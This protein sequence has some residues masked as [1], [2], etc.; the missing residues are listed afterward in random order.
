MTA[1][2][3]DLFV[4]GAGSGGVRAARAAAKYG[5]RTAIAEEYRVGG[6]CVIRGCVPKKLLV[7]A[8]RFAEDFEDAIGFG[9]T[10]EG[11]TFSWPTLIANKNIEVER[12]SKAYVRNV[13]AAGGEVIRQ[14]AELVDRS[15]IRL[16]D[17]SKITAKTI[18]IATGARPFV[19]SALKGMEH[20]ITS[21]EAFELEQLPRRIVIVGGG[22]IAVEFAGIFAGLGCE[23]ILL[24]R[25]EQILRGFDDDIRS[26][27]AAEMAKKGVEIRLRSE[28]AAVERSGDGVRLTLTDGARFGANTV[29]YATGRTPNT[30]GIGLAEAGV[31]LTPQ[32][33]VKV[34][35]YSQSTMPGIY[36]VG[37]VTNRINLTP[38]AVR[39]GQAFA[40]TVFGGRPTAVD[41]T[42]VPSAVFSQPEIGTVGLTER[43]AREKHRSVDIY[44]QSF[45][46]MKHT[47]SGRDERMLMKL[48]VDGENGRV[49]GCHI[50][51]PGASEMAQLLAISLKLGA[52]KADFDATMALHPTAGE[53]LVTM[54]EKWAGK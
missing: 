47:L 22:Y 30:D 29:M 37:D 20:V 46:P 7:Y 50:M 39:E 1:F 16:G 8:S 45:R 28:V 34:D 48:V 4:I 21:N 3:Y 23:T 6:T 33:A 52:T 36:A 49:L 14:R 11:V 41:Y 26:G 5:A 44:K 27:L 54:R 9:W 38:V 18:L 53:E 17:G 31:E 12:L 42:N 32:A 25:G 43:M 2:D 19:P 24:Y 15:T 40:D 51:G 35:A 13:E 10:S